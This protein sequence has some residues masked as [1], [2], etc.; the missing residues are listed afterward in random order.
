MCY[1]F[2]MKITVLSA[3]LMLA[4]GFT[5]LIGHAQQQAEGGLVACTGIDCNFCSA[6]ETANNVINLLFELM[7]VAAV[8][9]V[10]VAGLK[11]VTSAGNVSA[12]QDAKGMLAN[13]I[14][15]FIIVLS[16]WL[17]VDTLMKALMGDPNSN[18]FGPW[19]QFEG[20]GCGKIKT[21]PAAALINEQSDNGFATPGQNA[22]A[23]I[24]NNPPT[25]FNQ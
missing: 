7:I 12:M 17:I 21:D 8:I 23:D 10:V 11:L 1:Y 25:N 3:A 16:A 20:N 5:P 15:G 24:I 2:G 22:S 4:F 13:V 9:L 19:N 18:G 6:V 14:I